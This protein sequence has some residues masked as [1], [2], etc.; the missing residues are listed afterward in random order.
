MI[1]LESVLG[2]TSSVL[3]VHLMQLKKSTISA[4]FAAV[5][6]RVL[7]LS[8]VFVL[9]YCDEQKPGV[10]CSKLLALLSISWLPPAKS[11]IKPAESGHGPMRGRVF[12]SLPQKAFSS[13]QLVPIA[14]R[15]S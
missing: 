3:E 9:L 12:V 11:F 6:V 13:L 15:A 8:K 2:V 14:V 5:L 10:G 7:T 4:A 1:H